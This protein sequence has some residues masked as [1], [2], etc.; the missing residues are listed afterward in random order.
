[1]VAGKLPIIYNGSELTRHFKVNYEWDALPPFSVDTED[2]GDGG[3]FTGMRLKA[4]RVPVMLKLDVSSMAEVQPAIDWLA[5]VLY[6]RE[7]VDVVF[8]HAPDRTYK[9]MWSGSSTLDR[10]RQTGKLTGEI[11]MP[12]PVGYG[13]EKTVSVSGTKEVEVG[14]TYLASYTVSASSAKRDSNGVWGLV[15]DNRASLLFALPTTA[16]TA[17]QTGWPGRASKV[18]GATAIPTVQSDWLMLSP[19]THSLS[20]VGTGAATLK[21]RE[22][23][24]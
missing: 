22:G 18:A 12:N 24:L 6:V 16:S 19:G 7:P 4:R 17:V 14:G 10:L 20:L 15:M 9:G 5:S 2:V 8:P 23:W 3:I 13:E 11:V 1:M 21:Y